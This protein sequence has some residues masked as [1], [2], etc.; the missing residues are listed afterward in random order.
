MTCENKMCRRVLARRRIVATFAVCGLAG[1]APAA[2]A[3]L[4]E[5]Y[6]PSDIPGYAPDLSG[7]VV[8]RMLNQDQSQGVEVGGFIVRPQLS[9]SA[10]Y[11]N[12]I[13]G[14][15]N[16]GSSEV[17]NAA[18]VK[19]NSDWGRDAL[20][21]NFSVDNQLY[22][23]LP[24]ANQTNWSASVGGALN[25][26]N[27]TATAAYSH[28]DLH[29]NATD[30][31]VAGVVNPVPYT[32][33]NVRL[34]YLKLLGR[35]SLTPSFEYR[36]FRFGQSSGSLSINYNTLNHQTESGALATLYEFSPGNSA[37]AIFRYT[38]AQ[39][40]EE[41]TNNYSDEG[42]FLGLDFRGDAVI[43]YRLLGGVESRQFSTGAN[44][45]ITIP[46]FQIDSVWTPTLLDTVTLTGFRQLEDPTSPFALNQIVTTGRLE[47]DHELRR[48]VFL[49]GNASVGE[50]TAQSNINGLGNDRQTQFQLGASAFWNINRNLRGTISYDYNEGKAYGPNNN[51]TQGSGFATF[52]SSSIMVGIT[53][54]K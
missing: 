12:D 37:A 19:I 48:D 50:S 14:T 51:A 2:H 38:Q 11:K 28:L 3:Q 47:L 8:Q 31:G 41:A 21:A 36:D 30:L 42:G 40:G 13:L 16:S 18:S 10:G 4:I 44:R 43:Q 15:G 9:E 46:T 26:G 29:L 1:V 27:D 7:S 25:L 49:R 54:F 17:D 23:E 34:S 53:L 45:T 24:V 6:F 5:Q 33:D 52:S 20:G 32:V 35:F 39:F 22:P